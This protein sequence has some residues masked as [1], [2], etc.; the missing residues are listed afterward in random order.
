M[1]K[2]HKQK[3]EELNF[4]QPASDM[5]SALL[6]ILMLVILLLGLYLVHIPEYNQLDPY[7]G[8]TYAEGSDERPESTYSPEPTLFIFVP[9]GW[10]GVEGGGETPSP[11]STAE[12]TPSASPSPT[13]SPTPETGGGASGG[14]GGEG[15]GEGAG[16]GPGDE[17]DLG[18]KSAVYVMLVDAETERTIKQ[19]NVEF[20]LYSDNHSLQ[21]L[22][23]YYPE[24]ISYRFYETTDAGVFYLPE[25]LVLGNYELH[26]I[27]EPDGY[28]SASNIAFSLSKVYD[29]SDPLVV[30]VPLYPSTNSIS[31]QMKDKE[32]GLP[33][34]G[35]SF[36]VIANENIITADGTLRYRTG[37]IVEEIVCD[38]QGYGESSELYLGHYILRQR[39]IP[40]YYAGL[41]ED[42]LV[43]VEKKSRVK[44][45]AHLVS[46]VRTKL[47]V[48]LT[49]ELD[50][51]RGIS[52]ASF[53]ISS[54][55]EPIEVRTNAAG[56]FTLTER[57]KNQTY[58][59]HQNSSAEYY[60]FSDA[61]QAVTVDAFGLIDGS[62]E[63][64]VSLTNRIIR[65]AIGITDEFS[66][67]QVPNI[68]LSLFRGNELIHTWTTTGARRTFYELDEGNYYVVKDGDMNSRYDL[69]VRDT[70]ETQ[71]FDLSTSYVM[72]Y[73]IIGAT[74]LLVIVFA[75]LLFL[76]IRRR[77]KKA[78]GKA[79]RE[80]HEES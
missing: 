41:A 57:G 52:G 77:K 73:I 3:D 38:S 36:D 11:T 67:I 23:S 68:S 46:A 54:V 5:F 72:H 45:P 28:D 39:E 47:T 26:E 18:M 30:Q 17:P 49:D 10:G 7:A 4:W 21:I 75:L 64:T 15:G 51:Q 56:T 34:T 58:L 40:D 70:A 78:P 74:V 53:L 1:K 50:S 55:G 79:K 66:D 14:G 71:I 61:D 2:H 19:A 48:K 63:A 16:E 6:L 35:G 59:I 12:E 32:T 27:T 37:Q 9:N 22:N 76:I 25:K 33:V 13:V 60:R 20:E 24:R 65:V 69:R 8:D 44:S 42:I 43:S 29:W 31:V 80:K 62:P